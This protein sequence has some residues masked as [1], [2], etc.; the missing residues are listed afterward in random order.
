[1]AKEQLQ[2]PPAELRWADELKLLTKRD[3]EQGRTAPLGW[4]LSAPAV[5]EFVLGDGDAITQ[6]YVGKRDFV[7]RCVV[8]LATDAA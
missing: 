4:R 5:C 3:K 1:M 2:R 8:S 7:E 6:K